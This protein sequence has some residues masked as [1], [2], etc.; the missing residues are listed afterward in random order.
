MSRSQTVTATPAAVDPAPA[1]VAAAV[2]PRF[3]V[4]ALVLVAVVLMV[5]G[6]AVS[7]V[8]TLRPVA[9]AAAPGPDVLPAV[10]S[11]GAV[12]SP[13]APPPVAG[14]VAALLPSL[15]TI[16][17]VV[18]VGQRSAG[19]G[20]VLTA[21][22]RVVTNHH[23]VAGATALTV[24]AADG[25]A[26]RAAVVGYDRWADVAV[27][28][29]V[30]AGG[31]LPATIGS[32]SAL[33]VGEPVVAVGN[34]DGRGVLAAARGRVTALARSVVTASPASAGTS[35]R[36]NR[37]VGSIEVAADVEPGMSGGALLGPDGV[38]GMTTAGDGGG[39]QAAPTGFA[40]PM[41]DVVTVVRRIV[42]GTDDAEVHVGPSA[43]L[44]V[45][46]AP[47]GA[48]LVPTPAG[49]AAGVLVDAAD[50]ASPAAVAGVGPGDVVTSLDGVPVT[51]ADVL[52]DAV[53]ARQPGD[54]V[55]LAWTDALGRARTATVV[56][57]DGPVG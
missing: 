41:T 50:P 15:V 36:A 47:G 19:T 24:T 29:L 56:L 16:E 37:L 25:R 38:V 33:S 31:L 46:P 5:F 11:A 30:G 35:L 48:V 10:P 9:T 44:G 49:P 20:I 22:G 52:A 28:P 7:V 26:Y 51:S 17:T 4:E 55:V 8:L 34:A 53:A 6:S 42:S 27:L 12:T 18:G 23:V 39:E 45:R 14:A 21:D 43:T 1:A 54:R 40:I 32:D 13:A 57:A 2:P 3:P